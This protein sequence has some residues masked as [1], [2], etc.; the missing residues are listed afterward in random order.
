[1]SRLTELSDGLA[2]VQER[3]TAGCLAA[4]R[5][6]SAVTLIVVTKTYPASDVRLLAGIGVRDVGESRDQEAGPKAASSA[7][8]DLAWH[9]VGRL[10]SNKAWSAPWAGPP[11]RPAAGSAASCRSAW[12]ATRPAAGCPR[13][14]SVR[15]PRR[16][17]PN[18]GWPCT[19]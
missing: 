1:V 3:I 6:R 14:A 16:S 18:R 13:P 2:R 4:G 8:L 12:M 7:D 15:W 9:F 5:D 11:S 17:P 10:Q 19:E